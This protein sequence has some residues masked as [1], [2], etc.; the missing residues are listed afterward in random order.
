MYILHCDEETWD[1]PLKIGGNPECMCVFGN[2]GRAFASGCFVLDKVTSGL[3]VV[4]G[5][6]FAFT[7]TARACAT[8]TPAEAP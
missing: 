6:A 2:A 8:P 4:K 1:S 5:A 7:T 3:V